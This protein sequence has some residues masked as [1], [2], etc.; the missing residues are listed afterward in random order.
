MAK[1]TKEQDVLLVRD[2]K[3]GEIGV[4]AGLGSDGTPKRVPPKAEHA[5][6]FLKF[7]RGG[8]ILDN[9]FLNFMRQCKEPSR[10]GFYRV[11]AEQAD[12]LIE[13]MKDLL[14]NPEGNHELLAPHKIDMTP[15]H[16][17]VQKEQPQSQQQNQQPTNPTEEMKEKQEQ[18]QAAQG[19]AGQEKTNDGN[20][21]KKESTYKP[22]N[23]SKINWQELEE[24]WGIKRDE[25]EKSGDLKRMLNYG[26]SDLVSVAPK[27]D[28]QTFET[29]ARLAFKVQEDGTVRL[30]PHLVQT[31]PNLDLEYK[32]H[33]FTEE[34][35]RNLKETGNLGRIVDL[36][37]TE[38][39]ELKPS[40]VSIDRQTHELIDIAANRVRMRDT[41]GK[42]VLSETEKAL[43]LTGAPL[44]GKE[45]E[46]ENG[47]KF[48]VTL[49]VNVEQ[50]GVEFVPGSGRSPRKQQR[51]D[52]NTTQGQKGE[53]P[54]QRENRW[55]TDDGKIRP[56]GKWKNI[57]FSDEQKKDYCQGK[58][59]KLENVLDKKGQPCT[60]Y[61]KF[62]YDKGR[63]F[64]HS[65]NPDLA[66]S[67]APSNE[68]RVQ[69]AVNNE[70]KTNEATKHIQ[71]S[72]EKGQVAPKNEQQAQQQ[73]NEPKKAKGIR[74]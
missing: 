10:F 51:Q 11:P 39:G 65:Q 19:A 40:F 30:V 14:K 12:K 31:A 8:D 25:L 29:A 13:V 42:T 35:K 57:Q 6:D 45:I 3:T 22:I 1:K 26:K 20:G 49:Q 24:K 34:D 72:I 58:A 46:L 5:Q 27:F 63:P 47:R 69:V 21:Q 18:P 50:R 53:S 4:I 9:F 2:E 55:T 60:M 33:R 44:K 36:A 37:N 17:A 74:M 67:V 16:K 61:L 32:G 15:Y 68:S 62:N 23:E 41:I 71:Q 48:T 43:L 7:D 73:K 38:T 66:Q 70:G 52:G 54:K 64:T 28:G 59:V 56:I